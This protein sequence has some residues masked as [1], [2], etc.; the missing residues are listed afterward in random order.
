MRMLWLL[1]KVNTKH[2]KI[3]GNVLIHLQRF[4]SRSI[5]FQTNGPNSFGATSSNAATN[6][7]GITPFGSSVSPLE[8]IINYFISYCIYFLIYF[9][10][11]GKC[12]ELRRTNL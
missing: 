4:E 11:S 2:S 6:T 9:F 10:F 8:H 5:A 3:I 7:Q 1:L 12:R